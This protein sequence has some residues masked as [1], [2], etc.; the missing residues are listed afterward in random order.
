MNTSV[1]MSYLETGLGL[2]LSL[3]STAADLFKLVCCDVEIVPTP[4]YVTLLSYLT[5]GLYQPEPE[6]V[7]MINPQRTSLAVV[8]VMATLYLI[9]SILTWIKES[10]IK[11]RTEC[12]KKCKRVLLMH[13]WFSKAKVITQIMSLE[14]LVPGNPLYSEGSVP[15]CQ[16]R[17][18]L[19]REDGT[20]LG[21][22]AGCRLDNHFVT[23]AHNCTTA[24]VVL[25]AENGNEVRVDTRNPLYLCADMFAYKLSPKEWSQLGASMVKLSPLSDKRT[26]TIVSSVDKSYSISNLM[27]SETFGRC[28]YQG[29]THPGFSGSVY[30]SGHQVYGIHCHGG[31]FNGGYQLLYLWAKLKLEMAEMPE[32]SS[33][34]YAMDKEWD[35]EEQGHE[36]GRQ[37]D[38]K[39]VMEER[40]TGRFHVITSDQ[41][42]KK[43]TWKQTNTRYQTGFE[44][45][46]K[47]DWGDM[48]EDV[49]KI[50]YEG[51]CLKAAFPG[52]SQ[53]QE[54]KGPSK[55]QNTQVP[56]ASTSGEKPNKRPRTQQRRS[57]SKSEWLLKQQRYHTQQLERLQK[58]HSQVTTRQG[59]ILEQSGP[60]L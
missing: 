4:W 1:M 47:S 27:R 14:S 38:S 33:L 8:M 29:S 22:G 35:W 25:L 52:E 34:E 43:I 40:G 41:E 15:R 42:H 56:Q 58:Q 48:V 37:E 49:S 16:I 7:Y 44:V 53:A 51:E 10:F 2:G 50:V 60:A 23:P 28:V 11:F 21:I 46:G 32:T 9:Y 39:Y 59:Q 54:A 17:V 5:L 57:I 13:R 6:F 36:S 12:W 3:A 19:P 31:T 45:D 20:L 18:C 26:V 30:H 24:E 55:V